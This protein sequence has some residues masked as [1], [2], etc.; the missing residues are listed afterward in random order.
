MS[1]ATV[2][3]PPALRRSKR[4]AV[5]ARRL[6]R[7]QPDLDLNEDEE[8]VSENESDDT[9]GLSAVRVEPTNE[10]LS[11]VRCEPAEQALRQRII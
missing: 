10:G 1:R 3:L 7:P 11:D 2:A 6:S 9:E 5:A 4:R 8:P